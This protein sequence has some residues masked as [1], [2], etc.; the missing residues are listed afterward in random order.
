MFHLLKDLADFTRERRKLW[1]APLI[2]ALMVLSAMVTL[3]EYSAVAS[4]MYTLL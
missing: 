1:L 2:V 3:A 4:L